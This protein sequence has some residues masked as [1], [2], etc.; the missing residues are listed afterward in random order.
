[1][2]N[3]SIWNVTFKYDSGMILRQKVRGYSLIRV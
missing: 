2:Q 1:M 3:E